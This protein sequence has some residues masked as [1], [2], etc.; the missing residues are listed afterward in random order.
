MLRQVIRVISALVHRRARK[1]AR[2]TK[3]AVFNLGLRLDTRLGR[4][5]VL[6]DAEC[7]LQNRAKIEQEHHYRESEDPLVCQGWSLKKIVEQR[8][9]NKYAS[10]DKLRILIQ[11][12]DANFSPAGFSLFTNIAE[13]FAFLGISA[14]ILGWNEKIEAVLQDFQPTVLLASDHPAYLERIHWS[15][16]SDYRLR[17]PVHLGLTASIDAYGNTPLANR[18]AWARIN[19]V[20]FYFSFRDPGYV[21]SRPDYQPF[22]AAGFPMLFL[23][24]GANINYYYPVPKFKRDLDYVL[25]AT[26]KREHIDYLMSISRRFPGFIDGPGWTHVRNFSFSRPRDRFIYARAKIGL[27]V[28]QPDQLAY[29]CELN[30]RTYQLAA[31]GVPQLTDH[32]RLLDTIFPGC[33]FFV[34]DSPREYSLLFKK[35]ISNYQWATEGALLAQREVFENHTTFHRAE[36][37]IRQ[38]KQFFF[39]VH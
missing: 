37:F 19:D 22:F 8:F 35:M 21:N 31:C 28:H 36:D 23:P 16:L 32:A 25:I 29:A 2:S 30:E 7:A 1:T 10:E 6:R 9:I 14:R 26:Q 13:S 5:A 18:L 4:D 27:N 33:G 15:A 17:N 20:N 24:F 11:V 3:K 34:A 38:F 12:P 39:R